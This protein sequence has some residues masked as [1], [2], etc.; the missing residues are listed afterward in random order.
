MRRSLLDV[1]RGMLVA[2]AAL[3]PLLAGCGGTPA[4]RL[5]Q[6]PAAAPTE[7]A[8]VAPTGVT[9]NASTPAPIPPGD[10][11]VSPAGNVLR[12]YWNV[13]PEHIDPQKAQ[14]GTPTNFVVL[15]YLTLMTYD[16]A[17]K[18]VPGAAERVTI[19]PDG[20]TFTFT[21]RPN[22]TYSDGAPLTAANFE[23]AFK[24]LCDPEI[25]APY[26]SIAYPIVGCQ[27]YAEAITTSGLTTTQRAELAAL[28]EQVG[29]K[30]LDDRTLEVR[31]EQAGPFFLNVFALWIGAPVRQ[32]LIE[33]AGEDWWFDP[34]NYIGNGPFQLV[35]W[36]HAG[37]A[38]FERNP[39]FVLP[40]QQP[41]LEAIEAL[42]VGDSGSAFA[43]YR[44]GEL[45]II[46]VEP[47][48]IMV[49]ENDP[50]LQAQRIDSNGSCTNWLGFNTSRAPFDDKR[51]RQAFA[52]ALDREG[53]VRDI[54]K[55]LGR[56][57]YSLVPPGLPGHDADE[58]RYELDPAA[59]RRKLAEASF[60]MAQEI[61][62]TY[63]GGGRNHA[64]NE[65]L[66]GM[67]QR[68]LGVK[69][70]L[71]PLEGAGLRAVFR[72]PATVPPL[73]I[74]SWCAD[75]ADPQN[76]LSLVFQTGGVF[77]GTRG[78][79]NARFDALTHDADALP[80]DDPRRAELYAEAQRLLVDETPVAF[81]WYP[82]VPLLVQPWVKGLQLTPL[83][84]LPGIFDLGSIRIETRE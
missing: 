15:N 34:A 53:W 73:T 36:D 25:A 56:P 23:Y 70:V 77:S 67:L 32:D 2:L 35:E 14:G 83:D 52:Q 22:Q 75:Y 8:G 46:N 1:R 51:V 78:W 17:L 84:L 16:T 3:A 24:R 31:V 11:V 18:V 42:M 43:A 61:T 29:V 62:L 5:A 26:A 47:E 39:R 20:S 57:A 30:A 33:A 68:N 80:L 72:D 69:I 37:Y 55:G 13:E 79:S 48:D 74:G 10:A 44:A 49:V 4:A 6:T 27:A 45:D 81:F 40:D 21:L 38:R 50:A 82:T 63:A 64:S 65:Y 76:F 58:R 19:A 7:T 12:L 54:L 59:A 66:A 28:R 41:T 71:N 9:A 60:D